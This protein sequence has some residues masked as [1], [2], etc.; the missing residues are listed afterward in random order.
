[1]D[2]KQVLISQYLAAMDM[3]RQAIEGC[4]ETL[5]NREADQNKFWHLAYHALFYTHLYLNRTEGDFIPWSKHRPEYNFMGPLPWPPHD[6]PKIGEPY[7]KTEMLE[8][9]DHLAEKTAGLVEA[10]DL[11][12][13]SGFD[14]LPFNKM[15]LQFY[16]IRHLQ[17]HIGEL[18]ERLWVE[19][20][21]EVR[22]VGIKR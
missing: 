11:K 21:I 18:C 4:P 14:W 20:G 16:N 8:Y 7:S 3:L 13:E 1:M 10:L 9:Y 15:G 6:K 12:E 2:T 17:L 19:A 22:W 5:W